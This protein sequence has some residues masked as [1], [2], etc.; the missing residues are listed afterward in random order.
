MP[1]YRIRVVPKNPFAKKKEKKAMS[2]QQVYYSYPATFI[3]STALVPTVQ[4]VPAPYY[5]TLLASPSTP[6]HPLGSQPFGSAGTM[7]YPTIYPPYV[8]PVPVL[9]YPVAV[10]TY[11]GHQQPV[12]YVVR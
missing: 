1:R 9:S 4:T 2:Y 3:G 12:K 6:L 10:P 11:V 5:P 8:Q 7:M